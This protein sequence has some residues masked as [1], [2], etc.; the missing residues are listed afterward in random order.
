M[1]YIS[2]GIFLIFGLIYFI[3][4]SELKILNIILLSIIISCL[5]SY[6][7]YLLFQNYVDRPVIDPKNIFDFIYVWGN[8]WLAPYNAFPSLHVAITTVWVIGF[9]KIRSELFK[10]VLV[11]GILII[12]ST[13]LTKQHYFLDV[14]SGLVLGFVSFRSSQYLLKSSL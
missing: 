2:Y 1:I 11:W 14:L 3:K 9:W 13:V 4:K 8:S 5:L 12:I 10:P 6:G 7:V